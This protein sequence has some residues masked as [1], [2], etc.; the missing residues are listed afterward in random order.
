MTRLCFSSLFLDVEEDCRMVALGIMCL[1]QNV[2]G[3]LFLES[4]DEQVLQFY[5][6]KSGASID[7]NEVCIGLWLKPWGLISRIVAGAAPGSCSRASTGGSGLC[8]GLRSQCLLPS[9]QSGSL[10]LLLQTALPPH[11]A[12]GRA[13]CLLES[14]LKLPTR[15]ALKGH[16]PFS[17][18]VIVVCSL[19]LAGS[20]L[21]SSNWNLLHHH[22]LMLQICY[23]IYDPSG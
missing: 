6:R 17:P 22:Q 8:F 3:C 16:R 23:Q 12:A 14:G 4:S 2:F 15:S 9:H 21:L 1:S 18:Y 19:L 10:P 5:I 20:V 11:S 7:E 13:A